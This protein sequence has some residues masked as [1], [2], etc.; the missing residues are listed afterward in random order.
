MYFPPTPRQSRENRPAPS[1]L[2]C[3]GHSWGCPWEGHFLCRQRFTHLCN[4]CAPK[5]HRA[6]REHHACSGW[7]V[8]HL[9][10]TVLIT[11]FLSVLPADTWFNLAFFLHWGLLPLLPQSSEGS[12]CQQP[13][14]QCASATN[15]FCSQEMPAPQHWSPWCSGPWMS[16]NLVFNS[17][18]STILVKPL[19]IVT[20]GCALKQKIF[21]ELFLLWSAHSTASLPCRFTLVTRL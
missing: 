3:I 14:F 13:K 8:T 20:K 1:E 21:P 2:A 9:S 18:L 5:K 4:C 15:T 19:I 10:H 17:W 16:T 11:S 12:W 7:N 6:R